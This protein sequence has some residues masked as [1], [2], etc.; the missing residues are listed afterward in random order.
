VNQTPG[1]TEISNG[2]QIR[3]GVHDKKRRPKYF[4]AAM[5]SGT[6]PLLPVLLPYLFGR[7]PAGYRY[8]LKSPY[9]WFLFNDSLVT[10]NE[11]KASSSILA[12]QREQD[13]FVLTC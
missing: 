13:T 10:T 2:A 12:K 4:S 8:V 3:I 1:V 6:L 7:V 11:N 5:R 9:Y